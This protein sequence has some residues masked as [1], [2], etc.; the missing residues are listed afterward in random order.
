MQSMNPILVEVARGGRVESWHRGA[1]A[2]IDDRG[3]TVLAAGDVERLV[4]PRSALKPLQALPLVASG[5]ADHF[6]LSAAEIALACGSHA[7][8]PSHV[9]TAESMLAKAGL[10]PS[11]LECG[12]HWPLGAEAARS[13]AARGEQPT[14]LHNNCS[15]KHAGFLCVA[16]RLGLAPEGYVRA[17]HP[18]MQAVL[19]AVTAMTG[20]PLSAGTCGIDG[21]S[22]PA[23]AMPLTALARGFARLATG[24]GLP[25]DLAEAASRIRSAMAESPGMIAGADCFDTR[26]TAASG[27]AVIMKSGAEGM[28]VAT[29]PGQGFGIAVK[30]DDGAGRAAEAALAAVIG[31]LLASPDGFPES[32]L[33]RL[34]SDQTRRPLRNW[35]GTVVGEI[36]AVC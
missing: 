32:P 2:V 26:V 33:G 1:V 16:R 13:L 24:S 15:G 18:V 28:A 20:A 25:P 12:A 6:R 3:R 34:L 19:A 11:L 30:I 8:E 9:A 4:F 31:R 14:A 29:L 21:C 5:A 10:S 35:H 23:P 22:I 36:R 17:D 7:G 27:G